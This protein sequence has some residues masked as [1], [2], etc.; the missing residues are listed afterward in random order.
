MCCAHDN[1]GEFKGADFR[2]TLKLNGIKDAPFSVKNPQSNAT[3]E[4]MHQTAVNVLRTLLHA[5]PPQNALQ[6]GALVNSALAT[7]MHAARAS[8]NR[9]PRTTLTR[10]SGVSKRH[11]FGCSID[12]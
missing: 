12:R 11:V 5:H 2:R 10:C 4:L 8:I 3:C 1:G 9:A 7:T 6:A